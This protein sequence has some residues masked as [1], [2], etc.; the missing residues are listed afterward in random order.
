MSIGYCKAQ[1]Q[2]IFRCYAVRLRLHH[3]DMPIEAT[4]PAL[5]RARR[6]DEPRG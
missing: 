5:C 1:N 2:A 4:V 6:G 3:C